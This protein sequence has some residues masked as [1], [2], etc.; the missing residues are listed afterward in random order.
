MTTK[1][2]QLAAILEEDGWSEQDIRTAFG[3]PI[4]SMTQ[5]RVARTLRTLGCGQPMRTR[6]MGAWIEEKRS[7]REAQST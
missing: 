3:K 4:K 7:A 6:I 1:R 2:D 5:E